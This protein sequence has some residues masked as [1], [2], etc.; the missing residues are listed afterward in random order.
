MS[1]LCVCTY[2]SD[3]PSNSKVGEIRNAKQHS[4]FWFKFF[5]FITKFRENQIKL[6]ICY[7][8]AVDNSKRENIGKFRILRIR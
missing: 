5:Q 3:C 4:I 6:I 1:A 2:T 8:N 7:V